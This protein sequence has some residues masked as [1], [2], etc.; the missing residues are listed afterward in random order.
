MDAPFDGLPGL[1]SADGSPVDIAQQA[2][3]LGGD[4]LGVDHGHFVRIVPELDHWEAVASTDEA[5]GPFPT[6]TVLDLQTTFCSRAVEEDSSYMFGEESSTSLER[7]DNWSCYISTPVK[8]DGELYGTVCFAN[9]SSEKT[10]FDQ[11]EQAF[12]DCLSEILAQKITTNERNIQLRSRNRLL[13]ILS[14]VLRHNFRSDMTVVR[15]Y[16]DVL[17]ERIDDPGSEM[18]TLESTIED[19]IPLTNKSWELKQI[20][21]ADVSFTEQSVTDQLQ[22]AVEEVTNEYPHLSVQTTAPEEVTLISTSTIEFIFYE[23]LEN[24]ARHAGSNPSCKVT[25]EE[26]PE[27]VRVTIADDEPGISEHSKEVL[28]GEPETDLSH[29]SGLGLWIVWWTVSIHDGWID[30]PLRDDGAEISVVLPRPTANDSLIE[31]SV[32]EDVHAAD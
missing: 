24:V 28:E 15:G 14:R 10:T 6:G 29:G 2:V 1:L 22:R 19:V 23:L 12:V 4:F 27:E 18:E 11:T 17:R 9:K 30:A 8:I 7:G 32:E 25:V 13:G 16:V 31:S 3:E 21:Q 5:D 26:D 20:A